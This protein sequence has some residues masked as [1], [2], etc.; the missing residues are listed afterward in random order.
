MY[1]IRNMRVACDIE[2]DY[3]DVREGEF[4]E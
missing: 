3:I 2:D 4:V 1:F